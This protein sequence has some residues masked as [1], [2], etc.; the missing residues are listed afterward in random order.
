MKFSDTVLFSLTVC[1]KFGHAARPSRHIPHFPRQLAG[2]NSSSQGAL[3]ATSSSTQDETDL[4]A[5]STGLE[6]PVLPPGGTLLQPLESGISSALARTSD[7]TSSQISGNSALPGPT[8]QSSEGGV[9]F[10]SEPLGSSS[11]TITLVH[12]SLT[13]ARNSSRESTTTP[14]TVSPSSNFHS[15]GVRSSTSS[16]LVSMPTSFSN[17]SVSIPNKE[18][19]DT[20]GGDQPVTRN[21]GGTSAACI[22]TSEGAVPTTWTIIYT[23]TTT[24][25]GDRADYTPPGPEITIPSTCEHPSAPSGKSR[26][27]PPMDFSCVATDGVGDCAAPLP[28]MMPTTM[29]SPKVNPPATVTFVTTAKNPSVVFSPISTPRYGHSQT[30]APQ[31]RKTA[32]KPSAMPESSSTSPAPPR[33]SAKQ[34]ARVTY[35]ITVA[36]TKVIINDQTFIQSSPSATVEVT[37]E[38]EEFTINPSEVIGG[39]TIINRPGNAGRSTV[40]PTST[41]IEDIA[42]VVAPSGTQSA[43]VIDGTTLELRPTPFRVVVRG[44]TVTI[45]PSNIALSGHTITISRSTPVQTEIV[46]AGGRRQSTMILF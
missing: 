20:L 26:V 46:V 27:S 24:F 3:T 1:S 31:D 43:I 19:P 9:T 18:F 34:P 39:G 41:S 5:T 4:E 30:H 8:N 29:S 21:D 40:V 11:T 17:V 13:P 32:Q 2:F 42:V 23:S 37:V 33:E 10:T 38:G 12:E 15:E 35:K 6:P 25:Y 45:Q 36:P 22:T 16:T 28:T 44:Q 14:R 7:E